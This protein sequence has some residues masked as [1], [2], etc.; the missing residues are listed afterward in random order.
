MIQQEQRYRN[1]LRNFIRIFWVLFAVLFILS[2]RFGYYILPDPGRYTT[3]FFEPCVRWVARNIF[4]KDAAFR[5]RIVSD[6]GA[7]YLDLLVVAVLAL[8]LSGILSWI[9]YK[10]KI[11]VDRIYAVFII[12]IS[13][14]LSLQML[15]YGFNKVFKW[16][17]YLPEPNTLFTR[18]GDAPPDLLYWSTMGLSRSYTLFSGFVEV[19]PALLLLFR[20]TRILGA[21]VLSG[22]MLNVVWVNFS[23]DISVKIYSCF[24]LLLSLTVAAPAFRL[25][26]RFFVRQKMPDAPVTVSSGSLLRR[27][28]LYVTV[29][30]VVTALLLAEGLWVYVRSGNYNDDAAPR[31]FLHGAWQVGEMVQNDDTLARC[32]Q[33][34]EKVFVHRRGYFIVQDKQGDMTDYHLY[35]DTAESSIILEQY[36]TGA[37]IFLHYQLHNDSI[38]DIRG[39]FAEDTLQARLQKISLSTLP[40]LQPGFHWTSDE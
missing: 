10:R 20:R 31:P 6:S 22:V 16:Q 39:V 15:K 32:D 36:E 35:Y 14:Y 33:P 7:M 29:K 27:R 12:I 40:A 8:P 5:S 4:G 3:F 18:V 26:Y 21:F 38:L 37:V 30:I 13:Y 9:L 24:L 1:N 19:I 17:F 28:W 34:W 25:L 11:A 23:Y 2:F